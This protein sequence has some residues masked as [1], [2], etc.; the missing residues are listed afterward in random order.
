MNAVAITKIFIESKLQHCCLKLRY[1]TCVI[2]F[3]KSIVSIISWCTTSMMY[4][5][6]TRHTIVSCCKIVS[7][8][9]MNGFLLLLPK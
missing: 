4:I 9:K 6:A 8:V 1:Y 7:A 2:T 3:L 5:I